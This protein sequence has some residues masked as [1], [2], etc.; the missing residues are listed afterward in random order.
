M[1]ILLLDIYGRCRHESEGVCEI[2]KLVFAVQLVVLNCPTRKLPQRGFQLWFAQLLP[3]HV[4]I[5]VA[6]RRIAS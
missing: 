3:G 1:V 4:A 5:V 2:G 6:A